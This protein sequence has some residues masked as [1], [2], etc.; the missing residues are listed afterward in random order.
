MKKVIFLIL[1]LLV[2]FMNPQFVQ[3]QEK[4][5][6]VRTKDLPEYKKVADLSGTQGF[7]ILTFCP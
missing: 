3:A 1:T 4:V 7:F 2:F 6:D 5:E